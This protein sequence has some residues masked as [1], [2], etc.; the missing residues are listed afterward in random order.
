MTPNTVT[1][2]RRYAKPS[3]DNDSSSASLQNL[4]LSCKERD[5]EIQMYYWYVYWR[6]VR[7]ERE[8]SKRHDCALHEVV[9]LCL[10]RVFLWIAARG[11]RLCDSQ[12]P[13]RGLS[14]GNTII[15]RN[16]CPLC[17]NWL[18]T[19]PPKE[20]PPSSLSCSVSLLKLCKIW[21]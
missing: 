5:F 2:R 8:W 1:W 14:Q 4:Q 17:S 3:N 7:R 20:T 21:V 6:S 11:C 16:G 18:K 13:S 10:K 9:S 19:M 12:Y 15:C